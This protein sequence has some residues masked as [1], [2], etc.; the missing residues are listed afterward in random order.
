MSRRKLVLE[1]ASHQQRVTCSD[2]VGSSGDVARRIR[3]GVQFEAELAT[4]MAA[5]LATSWPKPVVLYS[6]LTRPMLLSWEE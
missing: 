5:P 2:A 1:C 4:A 6:R 3:R